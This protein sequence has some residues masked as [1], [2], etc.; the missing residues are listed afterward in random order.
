MATKMCVL[1][2]I[3]FDR[4]SVAGAVLQTP[5]LLID[6]FILTD[7]FPQNLQNIFTPKLLELGT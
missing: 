1:G 4:P 2:L 5:L 6:S 7:P 3:V